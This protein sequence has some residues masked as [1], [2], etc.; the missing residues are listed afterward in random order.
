MTLHGNKDFADAFK[1]TIVKQGGCLDSPGGPNVL[2]ESLEERVR[3][4]VGDGTTEAEV[5]ERQD[6]EPGNAHS[7]W[8]P[9]EARKTDSPLELA[10]GAQPCG[11]LD[12]SPLKLTEGIRLPE[13]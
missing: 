1:L 13:L 7:L 11:R 6:H 8:K 3:L 2:A 12:F 10:E 5:W 9:E 4:R